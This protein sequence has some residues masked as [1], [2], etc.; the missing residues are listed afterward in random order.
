[1]TI[2]TIALLILLCAI[3][4]LSAYRIVRLPLPVRNR[5][6]LLITRIAL[7]AVIAV[8]FIEPVIMLERL[9]SPQREIPVLIDGS[10]SMRLFSPDSTVLPLLSNLVNW[11]DTAK[12]DTRTF[13][14]F[15]FGDSLRKADPRHAFSWSDR[16]SFFPETGDT[17]EIRD[18]R[19]L[20]IVTDGNWSNASKPDAVFAGKNVWY[21]TLNSFHE[22][23]WLQLDLD[24]LPDE[25]IADSSLRVRVVVQGVVSKQCTV[26]VTALENNR[27][28]G[29]VTVSAPQG[30]FKHE[31]RMLIPGM[32]PGRHLFRFDASAPADSLTVNLY[33]IHQTIPSHYTWAML[34]T[35]PNLDR[36]FIR[37][38]LGRRSEFVENE[39]PFS[40]P[41]DLLVVF[42]GDTVGQKIA[43]LI[44]P[45]GAILYIGC[46][47]FPSVSTKIT[48][49][50][51][52]HIPAA[53]AKNPFDD[54]D[55]ASLPPLSYIL[56]S[57]KTVPRPRDI[58][59]S[60]LLGKK[61]SGIPD[62]VN[63]IYTGR[64]DGA[65]HIVCAVTDLWRWDFLP[66]AVSPDEERI[67][68]VSDRLITLAREVLSSGLSDGLLLYPASRL[69]TADSL[70]FRIAFP[71]SVPVPAPARL[72][73]TFTG[74]NLRQYDTSFTMTI[75]GSVHQGVTIKPLDPGIWRLETVAVAGKERYR[76]SDS[77]A[78]DDDRSEYMVKGQ[79][80]PLLNEIAQPLNVDDS[81][82]QKVVFTNDD[83]AIQ[84]I[85]KTFHIS[86][87]WPLLL[88]LFLLF[89]IEWILRRSFRLD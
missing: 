29:R 1:M 72:S 49:S 57:K 62:T 41:S 40:K 6:S 82:L 42:G 76:F 43:S 14:F 38:A 4:V 24:S 22:S 77:V 33:R 16:K 56:D 78:I 30:Y 70:R 60:G 8:A 25:S 20:V 3:A 26:T 71:A 23:P 69:M 9:P 53:A 11:N 81:S 34:R 80:I 45:R 75:T 18:A 31:A 32:K 74:E 10:M 7:L 15:M 50:I 47:P 84:P 55:V 37:T 51:I 68:T 65:R 27:A 17:A 44:K 63:L 54:L 39:S 88:V 48:G 64:K 59:L 36:R 66:L 86:R 58:F 73:C 19:S 28:L 79:N 83:A 85:K 2:F 5:V 61:G 12:G 89:G 13:R 67:F 46:L 21:L 52:Y 87:S 35:P